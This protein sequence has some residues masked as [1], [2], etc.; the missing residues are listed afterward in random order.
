MLRLVNRS[1]EAEIARAP[2]APGVYIFRDAKGRPIYVG[3]AKNLAAR[4][5]SYRGADLPPKTQVMLSK[6]ASVETILTPDEAEALVLEAALIK[7]HRPRYNVLLKD[8]KRYP[9]VVRTKD[10]FP[11]FFLTRRP[12]PRKGLIY[13][14]FPDAGALRTA[15]EVVSRLYRIRRC[16]GPLPKRERP[17]ID[18]EVG[19]C[20]AP[21]VGRISRQEYARKVEKASRLFEG[22]VA[23]AA[24]TVE[25]EMQDAAEALDFETAAARRD[26]RTALETL[27][28]R[29][30]GRVRP[31]AEDRDAWAV[32]AS[33]DGVVVAVVLEIRDENL[34]ARRRYR[35]TGAEGLSP[36]ERIAE[37]AKRHYAEYPA[38]PRVLVEAVPGEEIEAL[39]ARSALGRQ[40]RLEAPRR[41]VGRRLLDMAREN[42][43]EYLRLVRLE[44]A[45]SVETAGPR[46]LAEALRLESPPRVIEGYDVA[47][48][49][50]G[51]TVG[52]RVRF[53]DGR[54]EKNGYRRYRI[55]TKEIA[56][57]RPDDYAALREVFERRARAARAPDA[58][59][60]DAMPDL[61][62]ID[63][64]RGQLGAA[65][66]GLGG[67]AGTTTV[68]A[69]AKRAEEIWM[70]GR[71][72]PLRLAR[73]RPALRLLQRVRDE[74][75]RFAGAYHRLLREKALRAE[76]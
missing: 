67:A 23:E 28:A 20:D 46:D 39:L 2:K 62:L 24:R 47:T 15:L 18:A 9:F 74:A 55:R 8:D 70:P 1:L 73:N 65:L 60:E 59:P 3:K 61:I 30:L 12:D 45:A 10:P 52:A 42:A 56:V 34:A 7:R 71:K 21:C 40:V 69:L 64:G 41:G 72:V 75:H 4:L 5:A 50:G 44:E 35:V 76:A 49:S 58:A 27:S 25:K 51:E 53:V 17:C 19:R 43:E 11:Q 31:G 16:P 57:G 63:G 14:P 54:P 37:A 66:E 26:E 38:P 68:V 29:T 6:A 36:E 32:A 48:L 33:D 13:G 22:K